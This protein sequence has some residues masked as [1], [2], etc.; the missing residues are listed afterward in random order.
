MT[1]STSLLAR[2]AA[3]DAL[4]RR[5]I[6]CA[7]TATSQQRLLLDCQTLPQSRRI[8]LS[9]RMVRHAKRIAASLRHR[10]AVPHSLQGTLVFSRNQT[11]WSKPSDRLRAGAEFAHWAGITSD[12]K[13][14]SPSNTRSR[15]WRKCSR[16]LQLRWFCPVFPQL[17]LQQSGRGSVSHSRFGHTASDRKAFDE[18]TASVRLPER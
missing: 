8:G 3:L 16:H 1:R 14:R 15:S 10:P 2:R 13:K 11:V 4:C 12:R 7:I 6:N 17:R 18:F 5:L 9:D